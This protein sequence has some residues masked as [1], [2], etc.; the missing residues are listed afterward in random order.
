MSLM[1]IVMVMM[2][3][4]MMK[5][6]TMMMIKMVM[7]KMMM[8]MMKTTMM[9]MKT[10]MMPMMMK[11]TIMM[12]G[13]HDDNDDGDDD[14]DDGD[15]DDDDGDDDDDEDDADDKDDGNYDDGGC[16]GGDDDNVVTFTGYLLYLTLFTSHLEP[17][18]N[19][20]ECHCERPSQRTYL[21]IFWVGPT[22]LDAAVPTNSA[23][24]PSII[25]GTRKWFALIV[26]FLLVITATLSRAKTITRKSVP[27]ALTPNAAA[28]QPQYW[29]S[30]SSGRRPI[31]AQNPIRAA[32][33][34][35]HVEP[36]VPIQQT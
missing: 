36:T 19:Q 8:M 35:Q 21:I 1:V 31:D 16:G 22:S 20:S 15:E 13:D 5:T 6:T 32:W 29:S 28:A 24:M 34:S 14:D 17:V 3:P 12:N 7:V 26:G 30:S 10:T 18:G 23:T 11:T 4:M 27:T 9:V 2:M 33:T 25:A